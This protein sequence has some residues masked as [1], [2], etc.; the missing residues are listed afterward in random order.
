M[1]SQSEWI[2]KALE[3]TKCGRGNLTG[4]D[5]MAYLRVHSRAVAS[6]RGRSVLYTWAISGT[7][8]SSGLGSVSI[9][10]IES[11]TA[12]HVSF[13]KRRV[14]NAGLADL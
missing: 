3:K 5:Q 11:S 8:G 6:Y 13:A 4:E 9:E 2:R 10:Q 14:E 12:K 7:K 1:L